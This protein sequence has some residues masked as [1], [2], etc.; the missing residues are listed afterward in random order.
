MA[1]TSPAMTNRGQGAV[2]RSAFGPNALA[3]V[4]P[5]CRLD[6]SLRDAFLAAFD[7]L[8]DLRHLGGETALHMLLAVGPG[9]PLRLGFVPASVARSLDLFAHRL[10]ARIRRSCR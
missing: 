5:Q 4:V 2:R 10:P 8:R 6:Q 7:P 9:E 1:G 3:H